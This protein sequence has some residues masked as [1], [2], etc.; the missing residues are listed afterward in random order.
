MLLHAVVLVLVI[1]VLLHSFP[2]CATCTSI[3]NLF[4]TFKM[5]KIYDTYICKDRQRDLH[6]IRLQA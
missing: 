1:V 2:V 6:I 3:C 5:K 4:I